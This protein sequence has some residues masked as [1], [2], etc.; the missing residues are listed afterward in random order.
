MPSSSSSNNSSDAEAEACGVFSKVKEKGQQ[1][2]EPVSGTARRS[3][4]HSENNEEAELEGTANS[5]TPASK[6]I[7]LVRRVYLPISLLVK[8][9]YLKCDA[10]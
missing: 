10:N 7:S 6:F 2:A 4:V 5:S 3:S 8:H 9:N 1:P